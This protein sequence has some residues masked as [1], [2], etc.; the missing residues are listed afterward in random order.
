ML[1]GQ[2]IRSKERVIKSGVEAA[3]WLSEV[4]ELRFDLIVWVTLPIMKN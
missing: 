1:L 4:L 3:K 2:V